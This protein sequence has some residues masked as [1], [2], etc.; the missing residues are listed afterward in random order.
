MHPMM[1]STNDLFEIELST[2]KVIWRKDIFYTNLLHDIIWSQKLQLL[3]IF[4]APSLKEN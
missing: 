3:L 1:Q 4:S 2:Q